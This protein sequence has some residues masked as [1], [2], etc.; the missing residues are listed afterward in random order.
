MRAEAAKYAGSDFS[1]LM[2]LQRSAA[3]RIKHSG[4]AMAVEPRSLPSNY[5]KSSG[6]NSK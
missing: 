1:S 4:D 5:H 6:F 3:V 2:I